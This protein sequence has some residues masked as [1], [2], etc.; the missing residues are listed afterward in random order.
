MN[1]F[2]KFN[3]TNIHT[4]GVHVDPRV[5]NMFVHVEPGQSWTCAES[6]RRCG[7]TGAWLLRICLPPSTLP[8]VS[9]RYLASPAFSFLC[10][11]GTTTASRRTTRLGSTG[12]P[13]GSHRR[14]LKISHVCHET[15]DLTLRS[16]RPLIPTTRTRR[17]HPHAH[18][19]SAYQVMGG[20]AGAIVVDPPASAPLPAWLAALPEHVVVVQHVKFSADS[21]QDCGN[22]YPSFDP[23]KVYALS[24]MEAAAYPA[25]SEGAAAVMAA[26]ASLNNASSAA[27]TQFYLAN[28][29]YMPTVQL[30]TGAYSV[31]RIVYAAVGLMPRLGV[32]S[33]A[34]ARVAAPACSMMARVALAHISGACPLS[35]LACTQTIGAPAI[36]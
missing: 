14:N 19:S 4:H 8:V 31:L 5:D 22:N 35:L 34:G 24:E 16:L 33:D 9:Y 15:R 28:G 21:T 2:A 18:G 29:A 11:A 13:L 17:Y 6:S 23:F 7:A 36:S 12:E 26:A 3:T 20:L 30:A 25:A 32:F 27:A 1:T 10:N